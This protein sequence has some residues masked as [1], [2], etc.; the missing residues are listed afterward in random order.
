MSL[1]ASLQRFQYVPYVESCAVALIAYDYVLTFEREVTL[2][3]GAKWNLIK[4]LFFATRYPVFA[5]LSMV[6]YHNVSR[7]ISAEMCKTLWDIAGWMFLWGIGVAELILIVRTWAIWDR[8]KR[9]GLGLLASFCGLWVASSYFLNEFLRSQ[10]FTTER[11]IDPSLTGCLPLESGSVLYVV[12]VL[13]M[14]FE[15]VIFGLTI[16]KMTHTA[17]RTTSPLV[18]SLYRDGILFYIYLLAASIVNVVVL[19]T[20]PHEFANLTS[21]IQRALHSVLSTR[22]LLNLRE[23]SLRS[24]IHFDGRTLSETELAAD[25]EVSSVRFEPSIQRPRRDVTTTIFSVDDG[26]WADGDGAHC[27][28][29]LLD[30]HPHVRPLELQPV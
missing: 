18:W 13:F 25:A 30:G 12:Y 16:S 24:R 6:L 14:V 11:S 9:I 4:V 15:T 8:D 1:V 7:R 23:A 17:R 29:G 22:L 27:P 5:D 26:M 20:T 19:L 21:S 2:V 28:R 3:W 10:K